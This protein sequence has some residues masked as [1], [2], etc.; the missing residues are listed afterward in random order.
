MV[1]KHHDIGERVQALTLLTIGWPPAAVADYTKISL[2]QVNKIRQKAKERGFQPEISRVIL[3]DYVRD[4]PRSGRPRKTA[5]AK[6][7]NVPKLPEREPP[8]IQDS[9]LMP[10]EEYLQNAIEQRPL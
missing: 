8:L 1:N 2:S 10:P 3:I 5:P 7:K 9:T 6:E 4:A